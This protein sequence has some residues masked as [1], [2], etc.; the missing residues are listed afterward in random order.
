MNFPYRISVIGAGQ[1]GSRHLQGILRLDAT[2]EIHVVDPSIPSLEIA[3]QRAS[4]VPE[5]TRHRLFFHQTID[6]LPDFLNYA[7]VATTADVRLPVLRVL[8]QNRTV[9][10][11]LLE[12][13]LFQRKEDYAAAGEILEEAG[14]QAWVNCPRRAFPIYKTLQAFFDD[15]ILRHMD[16]RGGEWGLGCNAIHFIDLIALMTGGNPEQISTQFL[17]PYLIDS[18]R[19][20]FKEFIGTLSG[21]CGTASFSLTAMPDISAPLLITFRGRLKSCIVDESAGRAFLHDINGGGWRTLEFP[22]AAT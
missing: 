7:I 3:R 2:C 5:H 18:K 12:K 20:G 17:Y 1:L 15:D 11:L 22:N 10:N 21:N 8:L 14:T 19:K 16:V 13:V 4:E 6:A 9:S